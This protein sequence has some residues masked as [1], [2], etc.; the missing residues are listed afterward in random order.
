MARKRRDASSFGLAFL[1]VMSCGLGASVL[2]FLIVKHN[3]SVQAL[4][5]DAA[6]AARAVPQEARRQQLQREIE[7]RAARLA[8]LDRRLSELKR[9]VADTQ[10]QHAGSLQ[11]I[12]GLL[13]ERAPA[14]AAGADG[15]DA[16]KE[17]LRQ[18]QAALLKARASGAQRKKIEGEGKRQYLAG[19]TVRGKRILI[20]FDRSAS[21]S[22]TSVVN[23]I[24]HK[25]LPEAQRRA[26]PKWRWAS[27]ILEWLL[28][29][30]P[31]DAQ[32]QLIGFD[33]RA[34]PVLGAARKG[35]LPARD[36]ETLAAVSS[37][38]GQWLPEGGTNL[39]AAFQSVADMSPAPD[40]IYLVTDGLPTKGA[41]L[42]KSARVSGEKRMQFF[43]QAVQKFPPRAPVNVILLPI[44]GD[45][46]APEAF[47]RLAQASGGRFLAPSGD[48]P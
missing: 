15:L 20:L 5:A 44:E 12:A 17:R 38:A 23:I 26:T 7:E 22:D 6:D 40:A 30:L 13:A 4:E 41:S 35:W 47:W 14:A 11:E 39:E 27:S 19:L 8:F 31:P 16:L 10:R 46:A 1:D 9:S 2:I 42:F 29:H 18:R 43:Q 32:Y 3:T 34:A 37:A 36:R 28:A 24:R 25:F 48:W 45:P 33:E 21:M